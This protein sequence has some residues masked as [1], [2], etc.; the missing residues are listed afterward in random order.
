MANGSTLPPILSVSL[1]IDPPTFKLHREALPKLVLTATSHATKPITILTWP[2]IFN[3]DLSQHRKN[4]R[5]EDLTSNTSSTMET[6]K[7]LRR[8]GF[9]REQGG[10][11]D[12]YFATLK[13]EE[14]VVFKDDFELSRQGFDGSISSTPG[15]RYRLSVNEDEEITKWWIGTKNEVMTPPGQPSGVRSASEGPTRLSA[16]PV[17]FEVE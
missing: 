3:L 12:K 9:N 4:F 7:G 17:E 1:V 16:E 13:P 5:C 11:D 15:H 2:T 10:H 8:P 14:A 6:T